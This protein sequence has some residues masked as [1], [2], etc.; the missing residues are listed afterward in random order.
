[1]EK[2]INRCGYFTIVTSEKMTA[3]EAYQLYFGRDGSKKLFRTDKSFLGAKSARVHS[4]ASVHT[5]MLVEFIALIIRQRMYCL[6][7]DEMLKLN[8]R[9][10]LHD[11]ARSDQGT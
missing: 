5:K 4:A 3:Q 10:K 11:C 7:K 1:M 2:E 8:V 6:L 9:K